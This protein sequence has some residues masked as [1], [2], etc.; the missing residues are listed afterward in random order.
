MTTD[1]KTLLVVAGPTASGK[2]DWAL[3]LAQ[4]LD[5]EIISFDSRQ[6]YREMRIGTAVPQ[7]E[8]LQAVTH[9]FIQSDSIHAPV[10]AAQFASRARRL[11]DQLFQQY[12]VLVAV[13]GT[14]LYLKA[15]LEGLDDLP[16]P[17]QDVRHAL[18][19][20]WRRGE[21]NQLL[22]EL[23]AQ[24][25]RTWQRIDRNNPS[26]VCRALEVIRSSGRPY[27]SFLGQ[28]HWVCPYRVIKLAPAWPRD[29]LYGR[30]ERR[31]DAMMEAGLLEEAH[32]LLPHRSLRPL[33]TVGYQELFVYFDRLSTLDTATQRIKQ[34]TRQ[35]AKRQLT[36]LRRDASI[37]WMDGASEI[38]DS[39]VWNSYLR[40]MILSP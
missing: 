30:I 29:I 11:A 18:R 25:F 39:D 13:G 35:Y 20:S 34:H 31:V 36:W 26:R 12:D 23:K 40:P 38:H 14:G 15:W 7:P 19:E 16:E 22:E 2:T 10:Q 28:N 9:H 5:T 32:S 37:H 27:S 3:W 6:L 8:E 17:P 1:P 24:D 4:H 33:Q 21:K